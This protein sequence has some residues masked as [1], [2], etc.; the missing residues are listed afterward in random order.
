MVAPV[1]LL[2]AGG[3]L[4]NGLITIYSGINNRIREMTRERLEIRQGPAGQVLDDDSVAAIGRERLYEIDVQRP[5][6]LRLRMPSSV[7]LALLLSST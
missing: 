2:T 1:V 5:M 4:S 7:C 3:V 6:M